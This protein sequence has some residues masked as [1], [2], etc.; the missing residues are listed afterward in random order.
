MTERITAVVLLLV[1]T[2]LASCGPGVVSDCNRVRAPNDAHLSECDTVKRYS[3]ILK[4]DKA[5][6]GLPMSAQSYFETMMVPAVDSNRGTITWTTPWDGPCGDLGVDTV[7]GRDEANCG[8][9]NND[10]QTLR[11]ARVPTYFKVLSE[12]GSGRL[13][14]AYWWFYGFQPRCNDVP[15]GPPGEHHGD[16]EHVVITTSADQSSV[17]A[18]TY[19]FHGASYT[20]RSGGFETEEGRPVVYV[21]KLAHGSYHDRTFGGFGAGTPFHCCEYADYRNPSADSIWTTTRDYL[22]SL[23]RNSE[24]WMLADREGSPFEHE[25]RQYT[26]DKWRWGPHISYK[27]V[28]VF[29][30]WHHELGCGTHP[31]IEALGE[32]TPSCEGTGCGVVKTCGPSRYPHSMTF[33]QGL[34]PG[35]PQ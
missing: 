29:G 17:D 4:F 7:H 1:A 13:R 28:P 24:P 33:D 16:W 25:G 34:P 2:L 9:Q 31:T 26:I 10:F 27:N 8:M 11:D 14:I 30:K 12:A 21:G 6:E 22:V 32:N 23:D 20:R 19:H 18:V 3:P 15:A 5:H 35:P